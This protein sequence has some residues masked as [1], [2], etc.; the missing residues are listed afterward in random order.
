MSHRILQTIVVA[1]LLSLIYG[2]KV[3]LYTGLPE[4]E[5]NEMLALLLKHNIESEKQPGKDNT[6]SLFIEE[7]QTAQAVE[8]LSNHGY[9]KK[10][11]SSINDIFS[12]DGLVSTP[13]EERTR[14]IY[15]LS[16]EVSATLS[17]IDGVLVARFHVVLPTE[18]SSGSSNKK[19]EFPA[20]A[21]VFIKY[22]ADYDLTSYIPQMK[23][24]VANAIE[25]LSY[26]QVSGSL[27]PAEKETRSDFYP[28]EYHSVLGLEI[29]PNSV[30]HL[31]L[32][33]AVLIVLIFSAISG[34]VY[35]YME[36][37]NQTS[38]EE[39]AETSEP[40]VDKQESAT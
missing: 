28:T 26:N 1:L 10:R 7:R 5:A 27:F 20:S 34:N 40:P 11:F 2:C 23:S 21:S 33:L 24:I 12:D 36:R 29:N 19:T 38:K 13:F 4:Q 16:Q 15:G 18:S 37:R 35:L 32:L 22:N 8:I 39:E 9:P 25:G 3:E 30:G 14:Y 31:Y 6:A 17:Q